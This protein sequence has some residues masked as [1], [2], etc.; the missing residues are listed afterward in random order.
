VS[1]DVTLKVDKGSV[2]VSA[3]DTQ[4]KA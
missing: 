1:K 4:A 3:E 2:Y